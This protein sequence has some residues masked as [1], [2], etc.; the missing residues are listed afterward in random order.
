[1]SLLILTNLKYEEVDSFSFG[2]VIESVS[3]RWP[4]QF[5]VGK[6]SD[7]LKTTLKGFGSISFPGLMYNHS[8]IKKP[9]THFDVFYSTN[10]G[11]NWKQWRF[12]NNSQLIQD[13]DGKLVV[14]PNSPTNGENYDHSFFSYTKSKLAIGVIRIRPEM[15]ITTKDKKLAVG[16]GPLF[17]IMIASK[18]KRKFFDDSDS[19]E[20]F[21]ITRNE[22]FNINWFQVGWGASIGTYH[23]G[24][25]PYVMLN[26]MFKKGK[27]PDVSVA[28]IGL[29]FRVLDDNYL[30]RKNDDKYTMNW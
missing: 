26:H 2:C 5:F 16:T 15:G 14:I 8:T 4:I 18:H 9:L 29:Y 27:G 20:K 22:H 13:A 11:F 1:L 24:A 10:F 6:D 25:F 30:P 21:K 19:K 3:K 12:A 7:Q 23:F 28:E 17:E